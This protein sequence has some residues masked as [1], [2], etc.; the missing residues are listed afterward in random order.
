M[1]Q[2]EPLLL[3]FTQVIFLFLV[4]LQIEEDGWNQLPVCPQEAA[5]K[6]RGP[7]AHQR[8]HTA[9]E[10]R[11]N[12]SGCVHSRGGAAQA[13]FHM[14][15]CC[16]IIKHWTHGVG[17]SLILS[18]LFLLSICVRYWHR[19]LNPRKLVEVKFSHLSRN[20][21]LQRTM[22]LYRLPDVNTST[23]FFSV[24]NSFSWHDLIWNFVSCHLHALKSTKTPGLRSM[25]RR[26]IP[27]VTELLQKYLKRFQLAPSMGEQEV[28]HWFFPQDNI[29]DTY[30][31]E[32]SSFS[33]AGNNSFQSIP[34]CKLLLFR[35]V[36]RGTGVFWRTSL[37]STHCPRLWC[38]TLFIEAWRLRTLFTMFI[39]KPH[40]WT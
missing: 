22:K 1:S 4:L 24:S 31:V 14:Q 39:P 9:S 27:Q 8:D 35:S 6:A 11:R 21:T 26:D 25:E 32:V 33:H 37:V 29:I 28:A 5:F 13:C 18:F 15:V 34:L 30:V 10:L 38:T 3:F 2:N 40:S 17:Y 16:A 7:R 23:W 19:S 20:M 12:I 36:H